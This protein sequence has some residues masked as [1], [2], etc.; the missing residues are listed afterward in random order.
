MEQRQAHPLDI[1]LL[2]FALGDADVAHGSEITDHLGTCLLCRIRVHRIRR[3]GVVHGSAQITESVSVSP[4]ILAL[5][6]NDT[7]PAVAPGQ[8]WLAGN[9]RRTFVW[10]RKVLGDTVVVHPATDD[11]AGADNTFLI[12]DTIDTLGMPLAVG[13]SIVSTIRADRL[14]RYAGDLDIATDIERLRDA[15]RAGTE[16]ND[17]STGDPI[18][19]L[20]DERIEFHQMLA[21]DLAA[22]D[23]IDEP[24]DG[25]DEADDETVVV[26]AAQ[27]IFDRLRE[28]LSSW[29]G[30]ICEVKLAHD[31]ML[32]EFARSHDCVPVA[33]VYELD[34][35]VLLITGVNRVQWVKDNRDNAYKLLHIAKVSTLAV[36]EPSTPYVTCVLD[37][38]DMRMAFEPP[39]AASRLA[40]RVYWEPAPVSTA[41]HKYLEHAVFSVAT[42]D[43]SPWLPAAPDLE[44]FLAP[45]AR[46]RVDQIREIGAQLT[47]RVA[48]RGLSD[49]DADAVA[50]AVHEGNGWQEILARIERIAGE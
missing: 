42:S 49:S 13:A 16:V 8:L 24:D 6:E 48:F 1:D 29:R 34:A 2:D 19:G 38:R 28:D 31:L 15:A 39:H 36:A 11:L 17:L 37:N 45:H 4:Q 18:E 41:L 5:M 23:P 21:D 35:S 30:P 33:R 46:V 44:P 3:S 7:H 20:T 22:L 47:K 50:A 43:R 14:A 27:D 26:A 10:I 12:T 32:R 40:P 25:A 9:T